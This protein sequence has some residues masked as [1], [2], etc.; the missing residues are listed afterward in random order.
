M[1]DKLFKTE[2]FP[3]IQITSTKLQTHLQNSQQDTI[4]RYQHKN[5]PSHWHILET[6]QICNEVTIQKFI[7]NERATGGELIAF[8]VEFVKD[9]MKLL[10]ASV[11]SL[12][13]AFSL[14]PELVSYKGT[15][16]RGMR[17]YIADLMKRRYS[18]CDRDK[19]TNYQYAFD[20]LCKY[21][22]NHNLLYEIILSKLMDPNTNNRFTKK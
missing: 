12:L 5:V 19:V 21:I 7:D 10:R 8:E 17:S 1:S 14:S 22:N 16:G 20:N 3:Q 6:S 2:S 18:Y 4:Q 11:G 13:E 9:K 15:E